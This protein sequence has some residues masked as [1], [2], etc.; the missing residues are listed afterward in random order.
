[1][2]ILI[3]MKVSS[4]SKIEVSEQC[5]YSIDLSRYNK[6]VTSKAVVKSLTSKQMDK[7]SYFCT[8]KT[9]I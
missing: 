3:L 7:A 5:K 2:A 6:D 1:M 4:D 9:H 8:V